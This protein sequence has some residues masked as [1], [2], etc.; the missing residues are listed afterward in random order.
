MH[1][2]QAKGL[3]MFKKIL[4][5]GGAGY[6]GSLL[7]PQLLD[8][9]YH[10][11]VYDIMYFGDFFL[12]KD[13][14]RLTVIQ[15]DIRDIRKL[16]AALQG[17]EAVLHLACISNDASFELDERLSTASPTPPQVPSTG[18]PTSLTSP[19]TTRSYRS[20]STTSTRACASR[21]CSNI[22]MTASSA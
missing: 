20:R 19:K 10:V 17:Q 21:C 7:V 6:C 2:Q 22:P 14:P 5:T 12:P 4:V 18:F 3:P 8:L 15:G 9:G 1:V 13:H 11:T 16:S